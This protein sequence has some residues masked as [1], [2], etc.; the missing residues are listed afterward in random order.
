MIVIGDLFP[1]KQT[2]KDFGRP[3]T[4]KY[5]FRTPFDSQHVKGSQEN[6]HEGTLTYVLMILRETDLIFLIG[7]LNLGSLF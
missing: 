7:M 3:L 4:K 2:V 5:R 6:L 1:K